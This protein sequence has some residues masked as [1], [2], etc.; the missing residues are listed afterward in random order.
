M[1]LSRLDNPKKYL[2]GSDLV[3]AVFG[4]QATYLDR[5]NSFS[6]QI[7]PS[8]VPASPTDQDMI[9]AADAKAM[10]IHSA[11]TAG[12]DAEG[13]PTTEVTIQCQGCNLC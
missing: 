2:S 4:Y 3:Y 13:A 7:V 12:I 10:A 5:T 6:V 8:D 11:W 1:A 9:T